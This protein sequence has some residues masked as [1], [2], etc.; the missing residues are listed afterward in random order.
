MDE[1][2]HPADYLDY[3]QKDAAVT[4]VSP[5]VYRT[6]WREHGRVC[7]ELVRVEAA[8]DFCLEHEILFERIIKEPEDWN[9]ISD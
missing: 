3:I 9:Y 8:R 1:F 4:L 5:K 7:T 2:C 6:W